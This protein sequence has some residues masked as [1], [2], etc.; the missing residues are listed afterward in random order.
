V[1]TTAETT[2]G[3]LGDATQKLRERREFSVLFGLVAIWLLGLI[4]SP[5]EF[6]SLDRFNRMFRS[7]ARTAVVGYGIALLMI[8]SE[9]DLSVGSLYALSGAM[10]VLLI[11]QE[12]GQLGIS[13]TFTIVLILL[14]G[15]I[16][17]VSQG[18]MVTKLN[19]PS[20]IVTI[21]TL[22]L[23]R[24]AL[25]LFTGGVTLSTDNQFAGILDVFGEEVNIGLEYMIPFVHTETQTWSTASLQIVWMIVFL[26]IF[27][28]LLFYTKFGHHVRATGDNV[29]SVETTGVDPELIKIGCFGI[30]STMAAFGS[31]MLLGR[32]TAVS[33]TTGSG[34][35][36][37]VIAAVVLGG[38][39]LTGGEGT[40]VG[41]ALGAVVFASADT[42][43]NLAN[44][45][46]SGWRGIITGGF[47][48]AAIGLDAVFDKVSIA[49]IRSA[50]LVPTT[51]VLTSP[52]GFFREKSARKT[53]D[54][55]FA[56]LLTSIFVT[57]I[58]FL[59]ADTILTSGPVESALAIDTSN[60]LLFLQGGFSSVVIQVYFFVFLLSLLALFALQSSLWVLGSR[61]GYVRNIGIVAYATLPAPL[62]TV[63]ALLYGYDFFIVGDP[64]IT[65]IIVLAPI[66][67]SMLG[68]IYAGVG[69]TYDLQRGEA[70]AV[71]AAVAIA[72]VVVLAYMLATVAGVS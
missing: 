72:W 17:G 61:T 19:L 36:L 63:P 67:L 52:T 43:L 5:A 47:I 31:L 13:P 4:I 14:F 29:S 26:L 58:V 60:L 41:T 3:R 1:S 24:G 62:L 20:L 57:G 55:M 30:A 2:F 66:L 35:E 28:Y 32:S 44:L 18:L 51:E 56:Y 11:G 12:T 23:V 10:G 59:V 70:T 42:I 46:I 68:I 21:G 53:T 49:G 9:F 38:T 45:G 34:L 71:V 37:T 16:Y 39:K 64:L 6:L 7:A 50:Y 54:D 15:F 33:A 69:Q 25:R 48:I 27:H 40:M 22:T 65:G 8:T